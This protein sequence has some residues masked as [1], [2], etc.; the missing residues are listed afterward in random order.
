MR[1]IVAG[2]GSFAAAAALTPLAM[3]L[4]RRTG[5]VD[6]PGPLKPQAAPVPYLGGVAVLLGLGVGLGLGHPVLA[7]PLGGA[8][9]LGVLDDAADL[10][11][12]ARLVGQV[13]VGVGVAL[14]VPTR[15]GGAGG[16]ALV[17][18][19][20]VLL[21]NG[22]NFLDGLD[23]LAASVTA[24]ACVAFA[25]VVGGPGR[26]VAVAGAGALAGFLLYNRPPARVYL[27]DAG[28]YLLGA[29]LAALVAT[30]WAAPVRSEV[31]AAALAL[32]ALPVG[33]VAFAVVRRVRDH[34]PVTVGD[35]RHPYDLAVQA[36][37]SGPAAAA[38]YAGAEALAGA[39]A[40]GSARAPALVVPVVAVVAVAVVVVGV[41]GACGAL[42]PGPGS[43][44]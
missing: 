23:A 11:A 29:L 35:R 30:A 39:V 6:H 5:V 28:S 9:L 33:E 38:A 34:R 26:V 14:A 22:V 41:A 1:V 8:A 20:T 17:V 4:A 40:V 32:V 2:A 37:W 42:S 15:I 36:G 3:A 31:S 16:G 12:A 13:A 19:V 18:L 24:L 25:L 7:A 43:G 27:G 10:P 21:V 44:T